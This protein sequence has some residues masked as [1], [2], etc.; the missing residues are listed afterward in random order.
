MWVCP[1]RIQG[2]YATSIQLWI[3]TKMLPIQFQR[4]TRK[5]L[6]TIGKRVRFAIDIT[7]GH[8]MDLGSV[9]LFSNIATEKTSKR[10]GRALIVN[11]FA[12]AIMIVSPTATERISRRHFNSMKSITPDANVRS[13][14]IQF[15]DVTLGMRRLRTAYFLVL[16]L[17]VTVSVTP[18]QMA[19]AQSPG[20]N[21][22]W[23]P[24]PREEHSVG[25][26]NHSLPQNF[27]DSLESTS[28]DSIDRLLTQ[29]VLTLVPKTYVD[30][31]KWGAQAERF[32]GVKLE[33]NH[34]RTELQRKTKL[35]NHG[36][37]KKY[38]ASL[39]NPEQEFQVQIRNLTQDA[40]G[41][42]NFEIHL[43]AH[44]D[45]RAQQVE[46]KKGV[47]MLSLSVAGHTEVKIQVDLEV[48]VTFTGKHFPPDIALAPRVTQAQIEL[49]EFKIDRIGK[50]GGEIA[51]QVGR[52]AQQRL[53]E[54][55]P[56]YER[57]LREKANAEF[58]R[59]ETRLR[60]SGAELYSSKWNQT[61]SS[62]FT[63]SGAQK[64][65]SSVRN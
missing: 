51:Q 14:R 46:W 52:E 30:D 32:D 27:T 54:R 15:V 59:K 24:T 22:G 41:K 34:G 55:M 1:T 12:V 25:G 47:K 63:G 36:T 60:F 21:S 9:T 26:E 42:L 49:Q 29:L 39:R 3:A 45:F 23:H 19:I 8:R 56:E 62:I 33:R 58:A 6:C 65:Q 11:S 40:E 48:A 13:P 37:W 50:I 7:I 4:K 57:K 64:T 61:L 5:I 10:T 2:S 20:R 28:N 16:L 31:R 17:V 44:I 38:S 43:S 18:S 35:V 53:K